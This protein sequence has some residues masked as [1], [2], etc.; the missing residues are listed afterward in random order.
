MLSV[1]GRL[2]LYLAAILLNLNYGLLLYTFAIEQ[3]Y[4][5]VYYNTDI[6]CISWTSV[7]NLF[8]TAIPMAIKY[9]WQIW[10]QN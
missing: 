9:F 6:K 5:T 3:F 10:T 8:R 2:W 4:D 1:T 7:I